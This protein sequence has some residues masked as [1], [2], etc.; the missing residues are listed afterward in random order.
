MELTITFTKF[1]LVMGNDSDMVAFS[2]VS[3]DV[4]LSH[5]VND[6][7]VHHSFATK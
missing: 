7:F 2:K 6:E 3:C 5:T 4:R 1:H